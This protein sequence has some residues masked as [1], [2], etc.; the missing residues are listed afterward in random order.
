MSLLTWIYAP[1]EQERGD[2]ADR[3]RAELDQKAFERGKITQAEL[4][5]RSNESPRIVVEDELDAAFI[6]GAKEGYD[7]ETSTIKAVVAAPFKFAWASLPWQLILAAGV[8]L[9]LYMGGGAYLKGIIR[10]K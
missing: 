2:E 6:E 10:K 3:K 1:G 7:A 8:A 9:F 4:E 5:R